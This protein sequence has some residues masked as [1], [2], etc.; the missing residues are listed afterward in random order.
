MRQDGCE[1]NRE[2]QP[3]LAVLRKSVNQ[4]FDVSEIKENCV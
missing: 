3:E 1:T 2:Q 4:L